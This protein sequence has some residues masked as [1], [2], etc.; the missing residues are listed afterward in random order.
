MWLENTERS[1]TPHSNSDKLIP[2]KHWLNAGA[3]V[4]A[5]VHNNLKRFIRLLFIIQNNVQS[6]TSAVSDR[7]IIKH[8]EESK[9]VRKL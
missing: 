2:I 3:M 9:T 4:H 8:V 5:D 1:E 7:S 6:M